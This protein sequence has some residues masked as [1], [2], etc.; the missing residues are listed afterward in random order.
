MFFLK[1]KINPDHDVFLLFKTPVGFLNST[2]LPLFDAL[3]SY[4]NIHL[5]FLNLEEFA[6]N[7]PLEQW[8]KT[9]KI[10]NSSHVIRH[11]SDVLRILTL[12]KYTGTYF[13]LDVINQKPIETV[14]KNFACIQKDGL[15]NSAIM[16][17]DSL[18]GR[19]IAEKNMQIVIDHY[20]G[21]AWTGNGPSILSA[22]IWEMCNTTKLEEL[23]RERCQG[24]SVLPTEQ[25]YAIDHTEWKKM[26][27]EQHLAEFMDQTK[28]SFAVH[29]W[30]LFINGYKIN[31]KSKSGYATKARQYCPRVFATLKDKF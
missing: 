22:L 14:G 2:P 25:C 16:N 17:L 3:L 12:W 6:E 30:G 11:V 24:F 7:T 1:A 15:I 10:Y 5:N 20:N 4:K 18:L 9:G 29:F 31:I 26:V 27:E 28:N 13:D 23:T 8:V 21:R 19:T